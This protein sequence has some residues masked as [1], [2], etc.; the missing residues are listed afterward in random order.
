[1]STPPTPPIIPLP[2]FAMSGWTTSV[3]EK[4]AG[5]LAHFFESD[6]YQSNLYAG[7]ITNLQFL[8]QQYG[9]DILTLIAQVRLALENYLGR[10]YSSVTAIVSS[11][12]TDITFTGGALSLV[13][14]ATI[15]EA[16]VTYSFG[17]EAT[18]VDGIITQ[19]EAINNLGAAS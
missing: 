4:A 2:M 8:I 12:G 5:L 17:Y 18:T 15:V 16:G 19:I 14:G 13:I 10:Y 3:N 11:N 7:N 9:D 1:M 6:A